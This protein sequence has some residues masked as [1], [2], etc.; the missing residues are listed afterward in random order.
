LV[1]WPAC[2]RILGFARVWMFVME[3]L[4]IKMLHCP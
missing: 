3:K 2:K 1:G 4:Q